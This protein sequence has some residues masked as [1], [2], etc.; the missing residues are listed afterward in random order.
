MR[1]L[2]VTLAALPL[3]VLAHPAAAGGITWGFR[4]VEFES[5]GS[6][7]RA[8][9]VALE[10]LKSLPGG[11]CEEIRVTGDFATIRWWFQGGDKIT[12]DLHTD[13]VG[14]MERAKESGKPIRFGLLGEGVRP[15]TPSAKCAFVSRGLLLIQE[16]DVEAVYSVYSPP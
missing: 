16:G 2:L 13:A 8:K 15:L 10:P 1:T 4:V 12:P 11:E 6:A 9:L 5:D 14:A 3:L 7:F